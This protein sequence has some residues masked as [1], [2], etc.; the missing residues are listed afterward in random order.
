LTHRRTGRAPEVNVR[1]P[2]IADL[3][4]ERHIMSVLF[5][6]SLPQ[7]VIARAFR[8]RNGELGVRLADTSLFLDACRTSGVDV[9][10]WELWI[11]DHRW[12]LDNTPAP[13]TGEWCGGIPI[14]GDATVVGGEGDADEAE[15]QLPAF[16]VEGVDAAW[17]PHVRVNFALGDCRR[18]C[19][20]SKNKPME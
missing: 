7:A 8:A 20:S 4:I 12:A 1:F 13:A 2:P 16:E 19:L 9:V 18:Q 5:P 6:P 10:G 11:V 15:R 17:R 3:E 14:D